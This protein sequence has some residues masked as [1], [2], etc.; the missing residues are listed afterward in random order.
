MKQQPE[1]PSSQ[2]KR[3]AGQSPGRPRV[4]SFAVVL[5]A[6]VLVDSVLR[7]VLLRAAERCLFRPLWSKD[8]LD[9]VRRALSRR[10][11]PDE[12]IDRIVRAMELAFPEAMTGGYESLV[13]A[14]TCDPKDRHVLA[15][16]IIGHAQQIVTLNVRHFSPRSTQ[17]FGIETSCPDDFL[18][19]LLSMDPPAMLDALARS[20][21]DRKFP[22]KTI[23]EILEALRGRGYANFAAQAT[24]YVE[25]VF[26]PG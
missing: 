18:C 26:G 13:E 25:S 16:A 5:D 3:S 11:V 9:E 6:N 7:D 15:A 2:R 17:D 20:S 22:P 4:S 21:A 12:R 8:I 1:D 14:M 19:D 23:I 10:A 24:V